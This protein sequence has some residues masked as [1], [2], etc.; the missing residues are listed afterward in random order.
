[1]VTVGFNFTKIL[2]ERKGA[3]QPNVNV[4]TNINIKSVANSDIADPKKTLVK[5]EFQFN[6]NYEPGIG[7]VELDGELIE[8]Y[9]KDLAEKVITGWNT[10]KKL[11]S[12]LMNGLLNSILGRSNVEAL[13]ISR[14]LGLPSPI[15][16]PKVEVREEKPVVGII[17]P[18]KKDQKPEATPA[19]KKEEKKKK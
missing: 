18:V 4:T 17:E 16:L 19:I 3:S 10:N 8:I 11:P 15:A 2:A 9:D 6:C 7:K 1:M 5:F 14:E 12:D 13:V